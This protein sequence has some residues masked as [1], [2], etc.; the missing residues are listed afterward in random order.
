M[1]RFFKNRDLN[2]DEGI[3]FVMAEQSLTFGEEMWKAGRDY[4]KRNLSSE[5]TKL[6]II[7]ILDDCGETVCY[8]WQDN[9]ANREFRMLKELEK[10]QGTKQ[11]G[12]IYPDIREIVACGCNELAYF[13]SNTL[14]G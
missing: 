9:E 13:L 5:L 2:R 3:T 11:F 6:P 8:G 4:F 14:N 12:D 10:N 7:P 1:L